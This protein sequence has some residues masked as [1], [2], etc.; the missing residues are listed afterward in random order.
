[1]E[2]DGESSREIRRDVS[3]QNRDI[4]AAEIEH[5]SKPIDRKQLKSLLLSLLFQLL[6][7]AV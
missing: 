3:P 7:V 4:R 5:M 1:M 2:S 6:T